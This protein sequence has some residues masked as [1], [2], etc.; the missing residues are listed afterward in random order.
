MLRAMKHQSIISQYLSQSFP[1]WSSRN[2]R[3]YFTIPL[4]W[5]NTLFDTGSLTAQLIAISDGDFSVQVLWQGWR[6]MSQQEA[7]L[8]NCTH[9]NSVAWCRDVALKV[10][11]ETRV[12]ARTCMP[13]STLIGHES[14]LKKLGN[15]PL[16]A[17]LFNHPRMR[18]GKMSA[19]RIP[20][21]ELSLS[22]ARRSVFYLQ[23]KPILVTEA[24]TQPLPSQ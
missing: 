1:L 23:E 24:F 13:K 2:K 7:L 3:E 14:Q 12:Y 19:Y 8:L 18:R 22:W 10:K 17:Y 11:G 6:K 15:K 4:D 9:S 16:G 21:N 5:R 20:N